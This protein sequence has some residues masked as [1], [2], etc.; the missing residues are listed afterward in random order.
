MD[1]WGQLGIFATRMGLAFFYPQL[2]NPEYHFPQM[3]MYYDMI[4][5]D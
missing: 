3:P 5:Q 1:I 4:G 2:S